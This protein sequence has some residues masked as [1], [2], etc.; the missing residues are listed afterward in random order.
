MEYLGI[1]EKAK[2]LSRIWIGRVV[3][4][5]DPKR[6]GR[7]KVEIPQLMEGLSDYPWV[8]PINP[9]ALGGK[10]DSSYFAVPEV[11]SYVL[12]TFPFEDIYH[13]MYIGSPQII[14]THQTLFDTSYPERYGF[15]DKTGNYW[16]VDKATGDVMF[17]HKSG[18][19]IRIDNSGNV[20][21]NVVQ[22]ES[23]TINANKTETISGNLS[24]IVNGNTDINVT[25]K[26]TIISD[27]TVDIDGGSG[28]LGGVVNSLCLCPFLG[29]PHVEFSS[30]V[31]VSK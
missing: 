19:Q 8:S 26:T 11:G 15:T 14:S 21:I 29:S 9:P 12:I 4:N 31:K 24:I 28:N 6:L 17:N 27:G 16:Y 2:P 18:T 30:N 20:T 1:T 23:I 13:P 3:D 5:N 10:S 25:G 7:I 22:N